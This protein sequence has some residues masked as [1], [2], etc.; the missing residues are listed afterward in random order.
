MNPIADLCKPYFQKRNT[1]CATI[2][3][4]ATIEA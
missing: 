1:T 3:T 4:N 2:T